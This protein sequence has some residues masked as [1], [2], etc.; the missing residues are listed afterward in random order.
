[1]THGHRR[2]G[3]RHL[4]LTSARVALIGKIGRQV[5]A[6]EFIYLSGYLGDLS[7]DVQV[8][9][10]KNRRNALHRC[11]LVHNNDRHLCRA[12][13]LFSWFLTHSTETTS[14][15]GRELASHSPRRAQQFLPP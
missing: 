3:F 4:H 15:K 2:F 1:M 13:T 9:V 14:N 12:F 7:H 5:C 6:E 8:K 10:Q 11:S